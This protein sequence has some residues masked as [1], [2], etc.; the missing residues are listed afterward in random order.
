MIGAAADQFIA[1]EM[2]AWAPFLEARLR[3]QLRSRNIVESGDLVRSTVA[4][5]IG[6]HEVQAAFLRYGR[7]HDM[8]AKPGWEKG[9]F[10]GRDHRGARQRPPKPSKYYSRTAWGAMTTLINNLQSRYVEAIP[11]DI[12]RVITDGK[13]TQR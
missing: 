11:A 2:R 1:E 5:A 6:T 4:T 12:K 8:G 7:F 3:S 13:D 9:Q 10:V